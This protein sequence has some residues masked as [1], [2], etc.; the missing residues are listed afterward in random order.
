LTVWS[1][2]VVTILLA[3]PLPCAAQDVDAALKKG[4]RSPPQHG[5]IHVH[6]EGT[7]TEIGIQH[8]ALLAPEIAELRKVV[9]LELEHDTRKNWE[10]FRNAARDV[11]WPRVEAQYREEL[12]GIVTGVR[13]RGINL[14]IWDI[15]ALNAFLELG[16]YYVPY[17]EKTNAPGATARRIPVPERCSAFIATGSYTKAGGIVMGHNA[18]TG[19]L[20]G[21]RWNIVFDIE[22]SQGHAILM[23]GLAGVIHSG[24]DF[25]INSA[26]MMITETTISNFSGFDPK[27]IPEFVRAR[28]A[29]QYASSIDEFA[30]LM[31]KGNNGGYANN[32]LVGDRKTGEIAS[33]ELGL[34]NVT[35]RRTKDGYFAGSNFPVN[36]KLIAE[37]TAFP[38]NDMGVSAN[39]RRLRWE[40]LLDEWKGRI[41]VKAG[42]R[43]L[44]DT[45]DSYTGQTG[46]NER[47]LCGRID[48]SPRGVESW[49]APYAIG[50]A[51]QNKVVD[52]RMAQQMSFTAAYGPQC[53][54]PFHAARH[55]ARH[56]D[57]RWAAPYLRDMRAQPWTVFHAM[58][59]Q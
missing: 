10:F 26:G 5:W 36:P 12:H 25:G 56:P 19:Y 21:Q 55:L 18:W 33:L 22:P 45:V 58:G 32:W 24:D 57:N 3:L 15:V 51:V 46:A 2:L 54:G 37:E 4:F 35:L 31:T 9:A 47:T 53:G 30:D 43:F 28:K 1:A 39:A 40:K 50:G 29:M 48:L 23:D 34:K 42:Q 44:G 17:W 49:M 38:V 59:R 27:G 8:G 52:S 41:D 6:L 11:L 20:S 13:S 14:D 7:P 16:P